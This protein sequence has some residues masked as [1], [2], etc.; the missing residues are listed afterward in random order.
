MVGMTFTFTSES[1]CQGHPDKVCD[2]IADS[3]LDAYLAQDRTSRVACE[4]ACKSNRVVLAGEISS[5][6]TVDHE[7]V[8]RTAIRAVGYTDPADAFN[9]EGVTI[10]NFIT[11]QAAEIAAG[12]NCGTGLDQEQGAGDQ[13]IMFGFATNETPELMPLPLLLAH[14]LSQGLAQDRESGR[15][16]WLRPDGKTQVSVLY[17]EDIPKTITDVVVSAQHSENASREQ[18]R[19]YIFAQLAPMCSRRVVPSCHKLSCEPHW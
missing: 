5:K 3:I 2:Y 18:I 7:A 4:G 16:P 9:A 15:I 6:A 19:E 17:E 13:G 12:V 11:E 10:S 14:R 8:V 1:V